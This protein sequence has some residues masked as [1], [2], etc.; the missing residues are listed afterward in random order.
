MDCLYFGLLHLMLLTQLLI[1]SDYNETA[2]GKAAWLPD[3]ITTTITKRHGDQNFRE[4][5]SLG[6]RTV[7]VQEN[8]MG[9][10][11]HKTENIAIH[12]KAAKKTLSGS[13]QS[14]QLAGLERYIFT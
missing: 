10:R 1:D 9:K 5:G 13:H 7:T 12:G 14:F 2:S 6:T 4:N 11:I 3:S 8:G